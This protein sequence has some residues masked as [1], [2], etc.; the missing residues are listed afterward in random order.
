MQ[1]L[2]QSLASMNLKLEK[3]KFIYWC[4]ILNEKEN[5][6]LHPQQTPL[7][8]LLKN[9]KKFQSNPWSNSQKT[10]WPSKPTF[11]PISIIDSK[12]YYV[13][14]VE[15]DTVNF[16]HIQTFH[17]IYVSWI[18][19]QLSKMLP[20]MSVL[21]FLSIRHKNYMLLFILFNHV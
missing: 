19:R 17:K 20:K 8:K 13:Y 12:V 21:I 1:K 7:K 4:C 6:W 16:L 5:S 11:C 15:G 3:H 9:L 10:E 2:F 14:N 18:T